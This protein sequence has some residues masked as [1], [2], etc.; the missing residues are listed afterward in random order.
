[1]PRTKASVRRALVCPKSIRMIRRCHSYRRTTL[2]KTFFAPK[3][4]SRSLGASQTCRQNKDRAPK[5][6]RGLFLYSYVHF[7]KLKIID[8]NYKYSHFICRFYALGSART[9]YKA[10]DVYLFSILTVYSIFVQKLV[11]LR[12]YARRQANSLALR[13]FYSSGYRVYVVSAPRFAPTVL[14][15]LSLANTFTFAARQL[16]RA[17]KCCII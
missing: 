2:Y 6:D 9:V 1:M 16:Q 15:T 3:I 12:S 4:L 10:E 11:V 17:H 8:N 13:S 5:T 7:A 14:N